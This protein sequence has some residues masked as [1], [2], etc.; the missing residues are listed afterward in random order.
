ME[1]PSAIIFINADIS[2]IARNNIKNQ[3]NI[4]EVMTDV[5]FDARVTVDPNY[6]TFVHLNKQRI[7]IERQTLQ[8]ITNRELA[9]VVMFVKQGMVTVLQN[10]YGPPAL[11]LPIERLNIFNLLAGIENI[12][13]IFS[14][15]K[16]N[17]CCRCNCF[18]HLPIQ[19]QLMLINPFDISGV[20]DANCD[21]EYNN[22]DWL[23]RN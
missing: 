3:L 21:N 5:E 22:I 11:S 1:I 6:P 20:H 15:K 4:D 12:S 9:D 14:C 16:C 2:D 18:K 8:D 19:L 10:N 7:L 17:C 23:N 13:R